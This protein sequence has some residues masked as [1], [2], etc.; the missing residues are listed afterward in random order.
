LFLPFGIAFSITAVVTIGTDVWNPRIPSP[1]P[2]TQKPKK[3]PPKTKHA[4]IQSPVTPRQ[5]NP[6][7]NGVSPTKEDREQLV[8]NIMSQI[9]QDHNMSPISVEIID[10]V[11][12]D[13]VPDTIILRFKDEKAVAEF[14]KLRGDALSLLATIKERKG[15][16]KSLN[17]CLSSQVIEKGVT[18]SQ[19]TSIL[20]KI[21]GDP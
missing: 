15:D 19:L 17:L 1:I 2:K 3:M 11:E 14:I 21:F 8:Q 20:Q 10:T 4:E 18:V 16:S 12:L 5:K 13:D 6:V 7:I 9:V